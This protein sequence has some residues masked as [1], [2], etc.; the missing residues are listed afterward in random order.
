MLLALCLIGSRAWAQSLIAVTTPG[1]TTG[2]CVRSSATATIVDTPCPGRSNVIILISSPRTLLSTECGSVVK[3]QST[4]D[5]ATITLPASPP[6]NCEF[7]FELGPFGFYL[8]F[9]GQYVLLPDR[10]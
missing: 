2:Q 10:K 9:N 5:Y 7:A 1:L 3:N 4:S 6:A 8:D